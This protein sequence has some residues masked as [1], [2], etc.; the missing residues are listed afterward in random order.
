MLSRYNILQRIIIS[1]RYQLE[2]IATEFN[3]LFIFSFIQHQIEQESIYLFI[4]K[5]INNIILHH[6]ILIEI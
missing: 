2:S 5:L 3:N 4:L 1:L 6:L